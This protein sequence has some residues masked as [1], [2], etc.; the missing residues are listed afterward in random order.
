MNA[1][2]NGEV[3]APRLENPIDCDEGGEVVL[4]GDVSSERDM[5]EAVT[6]GLENWATHRVGGY[7]RRFGADEHSVMAASL[8]AKRSNPTASRRGLASLNVRVRL[9]LVF[10]AFPVTSGTTSSADFHGFRRTRIRDPRRK[11]TPKTLVGLY[12]QEAVL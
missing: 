7:A 11:F 8:R 10:Q 3:L 5:A 4:A 6:A 2:A 9:K 12:E 1:K